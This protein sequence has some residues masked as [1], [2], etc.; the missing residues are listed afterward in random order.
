VG[1]FSSAG[2]DSYDQMTDT[3]PYS[4]NGGG[5]L[6]PATGFSHNTLEVCMCVGVHTAVEKQQCA[7]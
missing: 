2:I 5:G 4:V 6:S 1:F 3:S 7:P